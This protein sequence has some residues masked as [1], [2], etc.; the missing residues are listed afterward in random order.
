ML[1]ITQKNKTL[2]FLVIFLIAGAAASNIRLLTEK[3][4]FCSEYDAEGCCCK[5]AFR[6]YFNKDTKL[7]TQVSDFCATWDNKTGAC[8]S[9]YPGYGSPVKGVCSSTPVTGNTD[10]CECDCNCQAFNN[11]RE[12][13]KCYKDYE[14]NAHKKCVAC[15]PEAPIVVERPVHKPI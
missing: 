11:H 6:F 12:C 3:D 14:F 4:P 1:F 8:L 13:V 5:C 7:C 2:L 15:V 9:C 10:N